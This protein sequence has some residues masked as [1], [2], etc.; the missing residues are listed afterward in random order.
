VIGALRLNI[1][2][3]VCPLKDFESAIVFPIPDAKAVVAE[4]AVRT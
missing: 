2:D 1:S 4:E 3:L